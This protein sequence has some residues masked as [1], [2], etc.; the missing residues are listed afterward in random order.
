MDVET[1]RRR[2]FGI[3]GA[4]LILAL[5]LTPQFRTFSQIPREMRV[6]EGEDCEMDLG[7][8]MS[9]Y[10][11]TDRDGVI[12][13]R[14]EISRKGAWS[15]VRGALLQMQPV[16]QGQVDLEFR[17]FGVV[18]LRRVQVTVMP[19]VEVVPGGHSIGVVLK[20]DGLMIVRLADINVGNGRY[21]CPAREAGI[22][23]GDSVVAVDGVRV[24][25]DFQLGGL[26]ERAGLANRLVTLTVKRGHKEFDV[27]VTPALCEET[28]R[29]LLGMWVRDG[30]AGVG[31]LS[32]YHPESREYMALGHVITDG[33]TR[34]PIEVQDGHIVIASVSSVEPG[35]RGQPGEKIGVFLTHAEVLGHIDRNTTFGIYGTLAYL[36]G[37][38]F[39]Q[40]AIPVAL[41]H[42]VKPGSAEIITVVEG[43]SLETF[44]VEIV[45]VQPQ[46]RPEGK[47]ILLRVK[48]P[49][50]LQATGGIV[51]GMSGSPIIQDGKVVGAITHV[52]VNDPE[53]GYGV[54]AEWMINEAG[55][56]KFVSAN[57]VEAPWASLPFNLMPVNF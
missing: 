57:R 21:R 35:R 36:P 4:G 13:F 47:G 44:L 1:K 15:I 56:G 25:S 14:G 24:V 16:S 48:D 12:Q 41:A 6:L 45:K 31:T 7:L 40:E 37:S 11:R 20:S 17:L 10:V 34:R 26:V 39:Y 23:M 30:T 9:L 50:L 22:A 29:Y 54:F 5:S 3:L 49:R 2:L 8:P 33:D 19:Q 46:S 51:Q 55:L 53:R 28:H 18:P 27:Q 52:L 32:F 43:N 38:P 42:Q